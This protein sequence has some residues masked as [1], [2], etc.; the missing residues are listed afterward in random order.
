MVESYL[1]IER[2]A[3][4]RQ[5]AGIRVRACRIAGYQGPSHVGAVARRKCGEAR[6]YPQN[7]GGEIV[8]AASAEN[9]H[10]WHRRRDSGPGFDLSAIPSGHGLDNLVERLDALFGTRRG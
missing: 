7:G 2:V 6:D 3:L 4:R 10:V 5:A 9:G 8:V 1:D